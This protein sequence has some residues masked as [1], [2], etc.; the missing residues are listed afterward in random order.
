MRFPEVLYTT[1]DAAG[2]APPAAAS[3]GAAG[4]GPS[5]PAGGQPSGSPGRTTETG[6][7]AGAIEGSAAVAAAWKAPDFLPDHLRDGDVSKTFEKVAADWKRLRD[8]IA[9]RPA[10]P[11][12]VDE[13]AWE[14]SDKV[15]PFLAGDVKQD[16][17]YAHAREAALKAGV[18]AP[19]FNS[20]VSNL[21]EGLVDA[22]ALPE[23]YSAD[24]ERDALLGDRAR[25]MTP[26]QKDAE[27]RPMLMPLVGFLDGLQRTGAIDK[28]GY[29]QLGALLDTASGVRALA[30]I[31]ELAAKGAPGLVPGG[32]PAGGG[33]ITHADLKARQR[34]ARND[35]NSFAY[36]RAFRDETHRMYQQVFG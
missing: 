19:V 12:S 33:Q 8:D 27:I 7:G 18:P 32:A 22:K 26:D 23:P 36:D 4:G 6:A 2:G 1:A 21:Y 31:A 24:R 30:K 29:A 15:K 13:Y 16:P 17:V 34:D 11:K 3:A 25:L 35:P 9:N 5:A 10:A 20:F 14:P 28:A